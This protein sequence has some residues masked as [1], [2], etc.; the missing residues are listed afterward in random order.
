MEYKARCNKCDEMLGTVTES[1]SHL[2]NKIRI[3]FM[4]LK[5]TRRTSTEGV[6]VLCPHCQE[7]IDI[8]KNENRIGQLSLL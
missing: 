3:D 1:V 7:E 2:T 5:P 6:V 4:P 8:T